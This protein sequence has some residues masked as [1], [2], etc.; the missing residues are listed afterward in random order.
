MHV[1]RGTILINR[2]KIKNTIITKKTQRRIIKHF[3]QLQY[4][5][6][7]KKKKQQTPKLK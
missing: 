6:K 3:M 7:R 2:T 4:N 5:T 1:P